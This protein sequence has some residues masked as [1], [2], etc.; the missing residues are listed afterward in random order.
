[1]A[2]LWHEMPPKAICNVAIM[3]KMEPIASL[4]ETT[5]TLAV[6]STACSYWARV[7]I[8]GPLAGELWHP[9]QDS[10]EL[11]YAFFHGCWTGH[12]VA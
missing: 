8:L 1:M 11:H 10:A 5:K 9:E 3:K 7:P 12:L 2:L 6:L 4:M